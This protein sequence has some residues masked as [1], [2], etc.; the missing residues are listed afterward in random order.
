MLQAVRGF[1]R[2]FDELF[3]AH[4]LGGITRKTLSQ[5]QGPDHGPGER[6]GQGA[7][8]GQM[9]GLNMSHPAGSVQVCQ[10]PGTTSK[11]IKLRWPN[12]WQ[13]VVDQMRNT[14][15]G[16]LPAETKLALLDWL[17]YEMISCSVTHA[18][19]SAVVKEKL[20]RD[21]ER[22]KSNPRTVSDEYVPV[23]TTSRRKSIESTK[24]AAAYA[25][26]VA[27]AVPMPPAGGGGGGLTLSLSLSL[28]Q[29]AAGAAAATTSL[30]TTTGSG[31]S[32]GT[33]AVAPTHLRLGDPPPYPSPLR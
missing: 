23:P 31:P 24:A 26:N 19:L 28:D 1:S 7:S 27:I 5:S 4:V 2:S 30:A 33:G 25:T 12:E 3:E 21:R 17:V 6:H 20:E 32:P 29:S 8:H 13:H 10:L 16:L 11:P 18:Y 22:A 15:Y 14:E 9:Q